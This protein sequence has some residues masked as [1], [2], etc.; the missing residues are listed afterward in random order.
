MR[1]ILDIEDIEYQGY[2]GISTI[3]DT[4]DSNSKKLKGSCR[5]EGNCKIFKLSNMSR[6]KNIEILI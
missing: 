6:I 3:N 4:K 5:D 2:K 1:N